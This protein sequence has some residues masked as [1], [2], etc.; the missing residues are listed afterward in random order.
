[1]TTEPY[2]TATIQEKG[3]GGMAEDPLAKVRAGLRKGTR[4]IAALFVSASAVYF[5]MYFWLS[6]FNPS[7]PVL[8]AYGFLVVAIALDVAVVWHMTYR[9]NPRILTFVQTLSGRLR[10]AD[11]SPWGWRKRGLMVAFDNGL[12]LTVS[13]NFVSFRLLFDSDGAVLRPTLEEWPSLLR[14]L[15][16]AK[17]RAYVSSRRGDAWQK[18]ELE[19][20]RS[21]LTSRSAGLVLFEQKPR[22]AANPVVGQRTALGMFFIRNWWERGDAV[23]S[24]LDDIERLLARLKDS[25]LA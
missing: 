12:L 13:Q 24:A 23:R 15:G 2:A 18:S 17:R 1:M 9:V 11:Y 3:G 14:N 25:P 22:G 7:F 21:L 10:E 5:V 19:R 8:W 20:V 6:T 4:G 16:S